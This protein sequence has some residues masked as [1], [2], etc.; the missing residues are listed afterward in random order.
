MSK[1]E[2][3]KTPIEFVNQVRSEARKVTWPSRQETVVSMLAVFIMV[4]IS[5]IFLYFADQIIAWVIR[6][7]MGL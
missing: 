2:K 5:A 1:P 7:I 6:L 3:K 4:T